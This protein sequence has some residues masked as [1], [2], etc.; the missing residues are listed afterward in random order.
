MD[1][2]PLNDKRVGTTHLIIWVWSRGYSQS[3][4][5]QIRYLLYI[6]T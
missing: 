4:D 2:S 5:N 6:C 1:V 3:L